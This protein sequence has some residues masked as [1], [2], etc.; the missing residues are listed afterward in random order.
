MGLE[1]WDMRCSF[2][3]LDELLDV[4]KI[5]GFTMRNQEEMWKILYNALKLRKLWTRKF[6]VKTI[7]KIFE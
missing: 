2:V 1:K 6:Y 4:I 7:L 3:F 5:A